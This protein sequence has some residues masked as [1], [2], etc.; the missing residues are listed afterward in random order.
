MCDVKGFHNSYEEI[1]NLPVNRATEEV[2]HDYVTVYILILN[3]AL[4]L[5]KLMYHLLDNPNQIR[6]FGIPVS[7]DPLERTR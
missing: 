3:E 2:V 7:D 4:P 1:T 5:G 6:S